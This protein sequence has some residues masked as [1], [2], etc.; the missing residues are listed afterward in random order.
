MI[1]V[2]DIVEAQSN[3]KERQEQF[4]NLN[5]DFFLLLFD[6]MLKKT[7]LPKGSLLT[8][9]SCLD[10][11]TNVAEEWF[12]LDENANY[13]MKI[14]LK[15]GNMLHIVDFKTKKSGNTLILD[16]FVDTF[17]ETFNF[18]IIDKAI[19]DSLNL[20]FDIVINFIFDSIKKTYD[21][22]IV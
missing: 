4:L 12:L 9:K 19:L 13:I 2:K 3:L 18:E 21:R 17:S 1:T 5:S 7:G 11:H 20:D 10:S 6:K 16:V 8:Y 15:I 22:W 14:N